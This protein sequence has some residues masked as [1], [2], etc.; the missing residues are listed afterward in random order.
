[1][2]CLD[3]EIQMQGVSERSE[4]DRSLHVITIE[5]M[6]ESSYNYIIIIITYIL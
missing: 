3:T 4:L 6:R 2:L 1:M 5:R